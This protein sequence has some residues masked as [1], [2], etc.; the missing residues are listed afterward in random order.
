MFRPNSGSLTLVGLGYLPGGHVTS[1]T[2]AYIRNTD[3]FFFLVDDPLTRK[4]LES[5]R[6]GAVSLSRFA[7]KG[8][9]LT[10]CCNDMVERILDEVRQGRKVCAAFPGHPGVGVYP[11][12]E[13]LRQ[14]RAEGLKTRMIPAVSA[15]DCL[16]ADLGVDPA[17]GCQFFAAN[18]LLT[19]KCRLD[20]RSSLIIFQPG[21]IGITRYRTGGRV[22]RAGIRRL[23]ERLLEF[24]PA[25]HEVIVYEASMVPIAGPKIE[26]VLLAKLPQ[27]NLSPISTVYIP[28]I[29]P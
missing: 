13:A 23:V 8:R 15:P 1:E 26:R 27:A 4:W 3:R 20:R 12:R 14:A 16:F 25:H 9:S 6:P 18:Q 22:P 21:A 2:L 11:T 29:R 19:R 10:D 17:G 28:A 5:I 24:Y 7:R